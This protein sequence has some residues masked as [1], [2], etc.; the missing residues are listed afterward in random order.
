MDDL[1]GIRLDHEFPISVWLL[2]CARDDVADRDSRER[3]VG[4]ELSCFW[5]DDALEGVVR[6]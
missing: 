4:V 1:G 2:G 6:A 5:P 3:L